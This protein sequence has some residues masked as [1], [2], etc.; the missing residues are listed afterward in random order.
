MKL[1]K[2]KQQYFILSLQN[3]ISSL[4]NLNM[5]LDNIYE[6][7]VEPNAIFENEHCLIITGVS[8]QLIDEN[9]YYIDVS[10]RQLNQEE[11]SKRIYADDKLAIIL[12][13]MTKKIYLI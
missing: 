4:L 13:R 12:R 1:T 8:E 6:V 7:L 10:C 2:I 11:V 5:A 3:Q 9:G